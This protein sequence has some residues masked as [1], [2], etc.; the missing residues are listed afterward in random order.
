MNR[1]RLKIGK[2]KNTNAFDARRN[3]IDKEEREI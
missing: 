3:N 2:R 1:T